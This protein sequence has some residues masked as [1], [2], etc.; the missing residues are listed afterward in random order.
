VLGHGNFETIQCEEESCYRKEGAV[1]SEEVSPQ[2]S[3]QEIQAKKG[4]RHDQR[5]PARS[6]QEDDG[7]KGSEE[8]NQEEGS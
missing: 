5:W 8:G 7:E 3:R 1:I 6:R 4:H 2:V